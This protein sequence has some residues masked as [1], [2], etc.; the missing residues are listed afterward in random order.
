MVRSRTITALAGLIFGIVLSVAAW[1]Y[2]DTL[3]LFLFL[4]FVPFIFGGDSRGTA[5]GTDRSPAV[6]QCP[7]CSFRT[8]DPEFE[9]CPRDGHRLRERDDR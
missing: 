4:P 5:T 9:Y 8:T 6:R 2:F 3:L 1:V 7:Q